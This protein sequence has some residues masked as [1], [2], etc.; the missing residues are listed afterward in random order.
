MQKDNNFV[1][2][3][4]VGEMIYENVSEYL[5]QYQN[6]DSPLLTKITNKLCDFF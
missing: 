1:D 4:K 3:K 5:Y 6:I 2:F